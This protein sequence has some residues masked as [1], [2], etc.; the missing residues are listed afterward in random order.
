MITIF[1]KLFPNSSYLESFKYYNY[2]LGLLSIQTRIKS[3]GR[4]KDDGEEDNNVGGFEFFC[5][6]HIFDMDDTTYRAIYSE[7][8][9]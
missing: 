8:E 6:M 5:S 3:S 1:N 2:D 4:G 7:R 9:Q